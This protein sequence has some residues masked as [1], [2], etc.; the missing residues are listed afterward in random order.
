MYNQNNEKVVNS[1]FDL[2]DNDFMVNYLMDP[3]HAFPRTNSNQNFIGLQQNFSLLD[4]QYEQ[5]EM[6]LEEPIAD[7]K[8]QKQ[9]KRKTQKSNQS[10]P[11]KQ[12]DPFQYKNNLKNTYINKITNL[13]QQDSQKLLQQQQAKFRTSEEDRHDKNNSVSYQD[14]EDSTQ[15]K[16]LRNR[17]C[18]RNSRKRKKIYIELL[19]HRVKQLND[20]LEKQKLLNKTSAGYLNK[21]SQN[22]QLQ[23]FFLGRQQLYEKLEKSIQNKAD[24]N[25]LNLLLDSM[26][27]RVG[28]GGKERVSASNYFFNQ[29]LEICFPVHVRYMLW[30]ASESK[31]LFADQ[32]DQQQQDGQPQW[33]LD[34]TNDLQI[35][36]A[37]KKQMKKSQRRIISDK[38]KLLEI[39]SQ[40]QE[41][42]EQLYNKTSQV[43]NFVDEL[44]NILNP[45]QVGKF[46][47]GLE[48]NKFR[49]EMA[50]SKI[51]NIFD[52]HSEDEEVDVEVKEEDSI[53]EPARKKIQI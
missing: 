3:P 44:R 6:K 52:D 26:R 16:L 40:F 37:Q 8:K 18:A 5:M 29:I 36:E 13:V 24:D 30:A 46:L 20:E 45:T 51:W 48:K 38:N 12:K 35:T 34:L 1:L 28:G 10:E 17:E 47:I 33:L 11:I 4:N 9:K 42:K 15:A 22:Q 27:F 41:I 43:E 21:M 32:L 23:G 19:E 7:A 49:R 39:L 50:I 14:I 25:E 31:D 53:E 2:V